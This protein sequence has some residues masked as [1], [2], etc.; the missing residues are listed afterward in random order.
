M[1]FNC[2]AGSVIEGV[3]EEEGREI[4]KRGRKKGRVQRRKEWKKKKEK[5]RRGEEERIGEQRGR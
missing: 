2:F 5:K 3:T 1:E 4:E